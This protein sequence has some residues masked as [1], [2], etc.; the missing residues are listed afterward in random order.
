MGAM[1]RRKG[2]RGELEVAAV[3]TEA[4]FPARRDGR[5]TADLLH[6]LPGRLHL[7]IKHQERIQI[8][9]WLRQA[10]TD[11]A[12]QKLTPAVVWRKNRMPWQITLG[13]DAFLEIMKEGA[14]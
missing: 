8:L 4:G 9:E 5:L 14:K 6:T 10:E 13:L 1:E 3:L 7:E 12:K 2:T 11:A